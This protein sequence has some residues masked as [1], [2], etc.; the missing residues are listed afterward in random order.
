VS[1]PRSTLHLLAPPPPDQLRDRFPRRSYPGGV[2]LFRTHRAAHG[3]CWFSSSGYGRF[4]LAAPNGTCYTAETEQLTLLETWAGMRVVPSTELLDRSLSAIQ[5]D[6]DRHLADLT[7]NTAAQFGVITAEK[8]H[9]RPLSTHP[10]LGRRPARRRIPR[11]PILG[12]PRP[13]PHPRLHRA[14]RHRRRSH[15]HPTARLHR[16]NHQPTHRSA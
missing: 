4:D 11:H 13:H 16:D 3:P 15:R 8:L 12:P 6:A 2:R 1:N 14:I 7:A 5:P 10:T 9:H